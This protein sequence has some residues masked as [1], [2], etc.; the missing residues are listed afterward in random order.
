MTWMHK[1]DICKRLLGYS[2]GVEFGQGFSITYLWK[3]WKCSSSNGMLGIA[4]S[5]MIILLSLPKN[6]QKSSWGTVMLV[7]CSFLIFNS[8]L[9]KVVFY[10]VCK[11][12]SLWCGWEGTI[13]AIEQVWQP[14]LLACIKGG[15]ENWDTDISLTILGTTQLKSLG[16]IKRLCFLQKSVL[17]KSKSKYFALE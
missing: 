2:Q 1:G 13:W 4:V 12:S 14:Q 10:T 16:T 15:C 7:T 3:S 8:S 11:G 6:L 5:A 9:A 17:G